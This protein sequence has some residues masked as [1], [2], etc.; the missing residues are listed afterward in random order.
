[1]AHQGSRLPREKRAEFVAWLRQLEY[2]IYALPPEDLVVYL[3]VPPAVAHHLVGEKAVRDYTKLPRDLQEANFA[4]LQAAS[5]V[6]DELAQ[7]HHWVTIA[8]FDSSSEH[9]RSP[10]SIHEEV[11]AVVASRIMGIVPAPR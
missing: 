10:E 5:A 4:H 8:C 3:K 7:Q 1:M 6:Y 9:M 2:G 11:L